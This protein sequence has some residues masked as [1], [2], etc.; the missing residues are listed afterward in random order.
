MVIEKKGYM[1]N[2]QFLTYIYLDTLNFEI[3]KIKLVLFL[4]IM[5]NSRYLRHEL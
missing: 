2:Y 3:R 1:I 5:I 4:Y